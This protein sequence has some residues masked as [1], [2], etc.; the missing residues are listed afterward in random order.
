MSSNASSQTTTAV[1]AIGV[2]RQGLARL[3]TQYEQVLEH[4][5]GPDLSAVQK[6]ISGGAR[7]ACPFGLVACVGPDLTESTS[8]D[9]EHIRFEG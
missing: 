1:V 4:Q 8:P 7:V 9:G 5:P 6:A 2:S 3:C